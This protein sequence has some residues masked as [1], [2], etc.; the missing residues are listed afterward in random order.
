[1]QGTLTLVGNLTNL[2]AFVEEFTVR[3][4]EKYGVTAEEGDR[5][6][7]LYDVPDAAI[8]LGY[9]RVRI[10]YADVAISGT[11]DENLYDV[12]NYWPGRESGRLEIQGRIVGKA[13]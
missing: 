6:F 4:A 10:K 12:V 3:R 7:V 8:V 2:E 9:D 13:P 1:V 5:L 11:E